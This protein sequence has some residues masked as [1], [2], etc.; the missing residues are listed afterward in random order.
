MKTKRID[1]EDRF[2]CVMKE[3][4]KTYF[5]SFNEDYRLR[6]LVRM[7]NLKVGK[8]LDVGCGGGITT[9]SFLYY[10]PKITFFG[11]DVSRT[12]ISYARKYGSKNIEYAQIKNKKLPY[13]GNTFD[14]C[15]CNDVLEHVPDVDSLL[16]EVKRV[17]KKGGQCF[18]TIPCE[19]QIG[20]FTWFLT[21]MHIAADLTY[22]NFGHIHPEFTHKNVLMLL[23]DHG[24]IIDKV[25]YGEHIF[26]Q[27][28]HLLMFHIPKWFVELVVGEKKIMEYSESGL[29]TSPKT[30]KDPVRVIQK[31]WS[32]VIRFVIRNPIYWETVILHKLPATAWKL[33]V[34]VHKEE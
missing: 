20:T 13:K 8:A 18:L 1:Y 24:F 15:L 16:D 34:L 9:E 3:K 12:A 7:V 25:A 29:L 26:S 19:G 23:V 31:L 32:N 2:M 27:I 17:L 10:F 21:K 22:R 14:L 28:L 11:C 4:S 30:N 33:Q 5:R 6:S